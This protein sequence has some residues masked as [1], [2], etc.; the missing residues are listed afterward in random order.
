ME[1]FHNSPLQR[2]GQSSGDNQGSDVRAA[3]NVSKTVV[4]NNIN[5]PPGRSNRED[6][7]GRKRKS[8]MS[9]HPG[10]V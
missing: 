9:R 7:Q 4:S 8:L 3:S 10:E 6:E 2:D 1:D 5:W